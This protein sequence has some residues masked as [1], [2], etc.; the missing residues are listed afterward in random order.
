[1]RFEN[2]KLFFCIGTL[3]TRY[4]KDV[5]AGGGFLC[6]DTDKEVQMERCHFTDFS[7]EKYISGSDDENIYDLFHFYSFTPDE[8]KAVITAGRGSIKGCSFKD[9]DLGNCYLIGGNLLSYSS[10]KITD[11]C[12]ENIQTGTGGIIRKSFNRQK[13]G[14]FGTKTVTENADIKIEGCAGLY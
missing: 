12:F 13:G 11:C 7:Y 9:M 10:F 8:E 2:S 4:M 6:I 14:L 5:V 1:M 3:P